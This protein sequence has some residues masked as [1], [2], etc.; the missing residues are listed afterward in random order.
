MPNDCASLASRVKDLERSQVLTRWIALLLI[1]AL[2]ALWIREH[3]LNRSEISAERFVLKDRGGMIRGHFQVGHD[4]DAELALNGDD[5]SP[6]VALTADRGRAAS[7]QLLTNGRQ[8]LNLAAYHDGHVT[9]QMLDQL[10]GT[11]SEMFQIAKS[12]LGVGFPTPGRAFE[13]TLSRDGDASVG[14]K[15]A[16][17]DFSGRLEIGAGGQPE[18][19]VRKN[20]R[21]E[22]RRSSLGTRAAAK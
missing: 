20:N 7:V 12:T 5:G 2:V 4:G 3:R 15:D 11:D 19:V 8:R 9:F 21:D 18:F 17:G 16:A 10:H 6:L 1:F 14:I 22:L 13:L